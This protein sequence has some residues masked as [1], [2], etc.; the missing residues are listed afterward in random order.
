MAVGIIN[1]V[2]PRG[3]NSNQILIDLQKINTLRRIL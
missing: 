3:L 1:L 2:T